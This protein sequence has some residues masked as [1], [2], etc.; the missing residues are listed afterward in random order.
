MTGFPS[1]FAT[2]LCDSGPGRLSHC[3]HLMCQVNSL[4]FF[5]VVFVLTLLSLYGHS[6]FAPFPYAIF[7][8]LNYRFVLFL[9]TPF[10]A[11]GFSSH[12]I[13][14]IIRLWACVLI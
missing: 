14:P 5:D 6:G 3:S 12:C 9:P 4:L 11:Q 1:P 2:L 13:L 8:T 10:T 7:H